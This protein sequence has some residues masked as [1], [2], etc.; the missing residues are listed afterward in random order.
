M[1]QAAEIP[2][3]SVND[4]FYFNLSYSTGGQNSYRRT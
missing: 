4:L 3:L 1:K 2:M